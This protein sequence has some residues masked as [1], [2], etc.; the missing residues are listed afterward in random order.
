MALELGILDCAIPHSREE[1]VE[2]VNAEA[3]FV[4]AWYAL[5]QV[6]LRD[7]LYYNTG[8]E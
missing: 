8:I 6:Q 7:N 2:C 1:M 4:D 3:I 5:A